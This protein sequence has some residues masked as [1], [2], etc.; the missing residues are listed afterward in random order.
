MEAFADIP[1]IT[2]IKERCR[3]CYTCVREC[4][5][6]AIRIRNGQAMV[7]EERCIGCGNC[8]TV[9]SQRAKQ[10]R[11]CTDV[12]QRLF[13][14]GRKV[15][16]C[17]AP[18]FPAEFADIPTDRLV[19]MLRRLGFSS[20][21]ET[22]FG[23][24]LVA[25]RYRR[26]LEKSE[27]RRYIATTCPV[28]ISF[29][30]RY[31]PGLVD[32]LA[33][34]V[35]PMI[36][37]ARVL[38]ALHGPDLKVVFIGPCIAKKREALSSAVAGE[39]ASVLTFLELREMLR[40]AGLQPQDV[41]PSD[42]DP[43][44]P[45]RGQLFA[46]GGGLL[47][48]AGLDQSIAH[49]N[50]VTAEGRSDAPQAIEEFENG[51]VSEGL[52]EVLSCRGCV[53]GPGMSTRAPLFSR[54]AAVVGYVRGRLGTLDEA[55]WRADAERFES[56]DLSR[57]FQAYD[58]RLGTPTPGEITEILARMGKLRIQDE[59]NCG[60]CGYE[61]CRDH[62]AAIHAGLA[63]SE[64]CLPYT[65]DQL[66]R[67][68][69]E[70]AV[71][72][73]RLA[74]AREALMHAE[75]LASMGQLAAGIAHEVNNPLGV[76]LMYAHL[77]LDEIPAESRQREDA[78]M[79]VEQADRCKRIVAGLLNFARQNKLI[80]QRVDLRALSKDA[81][82]ALAPRP[83]VEVRHEHEG[84]P[85][86]EIDRDQMAQVLTNLIQNAYDAMP[87][88][89]T[90]TLATGGDAERVWVKVR[91]TG[92]GIPPQNL[93]KVF[94]PFFTTKPIGKGTGLGLAV[95]YGIVKMH[96]GDIKAES[97]ADPAAGPTGTTFTVTVPRG[98]K[99][100]RAKK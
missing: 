41:E 96:R 98:L 14:N 75:K 76:V 40:D 3:V 28:V 20:V 4:P 77:M 12:V 91:D 94:E 90:L 44:R 97:N 43:P 35:S 59:L 57:T 32:S 53:M 56:L 78:K 18:S 65:I 24:D 99:E 13:A 5:A 39:V 70:L 16:A 89:G 51:Y 15:A 74:S 10:F 31:H 38:H 82:Q 26:L 80:L 95:T 85:F 7:L 48:A 63:E 23:A 45:G 27:G 36:A 83:G 71:S 22:A 72:N 17:L 54:R 34:I 19:G 29:V 58:Q 1:L 88:G 6:K 47:E 66:R 8:V 30:E 49:G 92:V 100:E 68:V 73:Q 25:E 46:V 42:F 9:C 33:P 55:S 50:V 87:A 79:I 2:T 81:A 67:A 69:S 64:M 37:M 11:R 84:D 60:A 86:A 52:M 21:H 93:T 61:S 62:A